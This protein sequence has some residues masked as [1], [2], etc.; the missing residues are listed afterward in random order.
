[1]VKFGIH[2]GTNAPFMKFQIQDIVKSSLLADELKFDSIWVMDHLNWTPLSSKTQ[3]ADAFIVLGHL[4][5]KIKHATLGTCVTDPHRRHP[6]QA[7]LASLTM[8]DLTQ[9]RFILGIGSGEGAN[10]IDF[11]V[12]WNKSVTR[13]TEACKV[14]KLLWGSS[15]RK[16][17]N[18]EGEFFQLKEAGLQFQVSEPPKLYIGANSPKTIQLTG[19]I[20]DGWIPTNL[21][22]DLFKKQLQLLEQ[23]P[24]SSEIE[25][26]IEIWISVSKDNPELAKKVTRAVALNLIARKETL[27]LYGIDLPEEFDVKKHFTESVKTHVKH[28]NNV[29]NFISKNVPAE[30]TDKVIIAGTPDE[31]IEQINTFIKVGV[32]HFIFEFT[33]DYFNSVKIF[34][35]DVMP[36]F[37]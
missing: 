6:A 12:P 4:A 14:I 13:L 3:I 27:A 29:M 10:L 1:M 23:N 30:I 7:A 15:I 20:A 37:K 2:H 33:G 21:T 5:D 24:R 17:V 34:A 19:E 16:T 18:F 36:H 35:T 8:Q 31:V 26:C 11:G 25:K 28:Q 9:G 22:P 32:E